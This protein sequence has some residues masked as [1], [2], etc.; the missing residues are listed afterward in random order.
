M[1]LPWID[2]IECVDPDPQLVMWQWPPHQGQIKKGAQVIVRENQAALILS[3]GVASEVY[4]PGRHTLPSENVPILDQLK[5]WKY[6]FAS[7]NIY[8]VFYMVTRQFVDLK[9]GTPAPV[10][11]ADPKFGQVRVRAFGSYNV[12]ISD[13]AKFFRE[14]A[15]SFPVLSVRDIEVQ[16]RDYIAAKF[17]EI[18]ATSG[19]SVMDFAANLS[20]V[21]AR[22][23]PVIAPYFEDLGVSVTQ[24]TI[25]SVTLPDEVNEYYDKVTGMNMIGD[26]DRFQRFNTALAT[27]DARN[28]VGAGAQEGIAMGLLVGE[29]NTQAAQ[30]QAQAQSQLAQLQAQQA[31]QAMQQ[32]PPAQQPPA[33]APAAAA[34]PMEKL[35]KLK[36]MFEADLIT[37]QEYAAKRAAILEE[38]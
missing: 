1:A 7:P 37:E 6:G 21:N 30:A 3:H 16:L 14:Y 18:M 38:L 26:M 33:A 19:I 12:R 22:L 34:D 11:M 29:M 5:G 28:T 36:K 15:G 25:V 35:A 31:M 24:F 2:I 17:G 13:P 20:S 27:A 4:G 9:W 10:M 8:D 32:Q 23:Q